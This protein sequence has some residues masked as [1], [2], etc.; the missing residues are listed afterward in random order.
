MERACLEVSSVSSVS[1]VVKLL[2]VFC[3]LGKPNYY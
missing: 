2:T 3:A 1:S